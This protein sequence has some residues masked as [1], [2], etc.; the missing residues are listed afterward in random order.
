MVPQEIADRSKWLNRV[1]VNPV[2]PDLWRGRRMWIGFVVT[3]CTGPIINVRL[4]NCT[5]GMWRTG[6]LRR[7]WYARTVRMYSTSWMR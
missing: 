6:C 7:R 4:R 3:K 2:V 5:R 1:P